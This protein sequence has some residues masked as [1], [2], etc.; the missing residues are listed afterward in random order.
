DKYAKSKADSVYNQIVRGMSFEEAA[1]NESEDKMTAERGGFIGAM[2]IN[3]Y[4][5][6]F[7]EAA[8]GLTKDGDVAAP[9]RTRLGWHIIKRTKKRP[10]LTY[11]ASKR[12]IETQLG[13]DDRI[14]TAR[15]AMV[16]RIK[17]DAGYTVNQ[18]VFND[19]VEKAGPDLQTYRWQIPEVTPAVV[20]TLGSDTYTNVDFANYVRNNARVRM[21]MAKGTANKEILEKVFND[22]VNEKALYYEERNLANKYPEF[23]ALMREYEEGIM[24]FEAT[25][26]NVWDKASR[27]TIGLKA[28]HENHRMDYMWDERIELATVTVDSS[29]MSKLPTIK[30]WLAKKPLSVVAAKAAKKKIPLTITR[31]IYHKDETLPAGIT[32]T[33][34]QRVDLPDGSGFVIVEKIIPPQPKSLDEARGY[35]IADYQDQLEKEWVASLQTKYP[36]KV[37]EDVFKSLVKK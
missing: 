6:A 21:G 7:E 18:V 17:K 31:R 3:Q 30:K 22:F 24:L 29:A 35:I 2:N 23:K 5:R 27:D 25:K 37:N 28:F 16:N 15:Q 32:W 1:R 26:L 14:A 9:I 12:K 11:E 13:R 36:V 33:A 4:E 8:Y 19:V 20:L 10:M 34:N